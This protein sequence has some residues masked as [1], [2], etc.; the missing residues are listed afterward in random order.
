MSLILPPKVGKENGI[1]SVENRKTELIPPSRHVPNF[2]AG[3]NKTLR[4]IVQFYNRD[5]KMTL[6]TAIC[7][8]NHFC[9]YHGDGFL[10]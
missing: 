6:W 1:H 2:I 7:I 9:I 8:P 3:E 10:F 5:F 4:R